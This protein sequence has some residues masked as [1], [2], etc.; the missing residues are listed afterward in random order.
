MAILKS[1]CSIFLPRALVVA[2]AAGLFYTIDVQSEQ[3]IL[4][5][6]D[7]GI[8]EL[9][10]RVVS[11]DFDHVVSDLLF[12]SHQAEYHDVITS[13]EWAHLAIHYRAFAAS[14]N[15]YDQVRFIDV[16]G[17]ERVRVNYNRGNP[18]IVADDKLQNK[19]RR[20][21]FQDT[22]NLSRNEIFIS[23][24][25]L[26][27]EHGEVEQPLKP[28]IRF[29]TPVFDHEGNRHGVILLNYLGKPLIDRF[30]R[31]HLLNP[32]RSHLL[33][34]DGYWLHGTSSN[35]EWGFMFSDRKNRTFAHKFPQEWKQ[36]IA[37]ES[38]QFQTEKGLYTFATV[39][40][41][42]EG[43]KS[44]SGAVEAFK[45]SSGYLEASAY[46]W[47]IVSYIPQVE[48]LAETRRGAGN[49]IQLSALLIVLLAIGSWQ[50]A[51]A[52]VQHR[53]DEVAVR[54]SE[55]SLN[56]AQKISSGGSWELDLVTENLW[57]SD[58][59]YRVFEI[60]K[61]EFGASYEAFLAAIHPDD[62]ER[63]NKAYTDSLESK[64]Q[65]SIEHRLLMKDGRVKWV[66]EHCRT[67]YNDEG[68]PTRSI[69]AVQ[70]ITESVQAKN[71][72]LEMNERLK[73]LAS[74]DPLTKVFNRR[75]F[76]QHASR[77][78]ARFKRYGGKIAILFIDADNFKA[79]NDSY[80]H[81]GGDKALIS[82]VETLKAELRNVDVIGRTG[83]DEFA[84]LL[85]ET[86][87]RHAM[88]VAAR[89]C[90]RASS[91]LAFTVSIGV[92]TPSNE[93]DSI[94]ILINN[95]DK[96]MYTAKERGRNQVVN[97]GDS[98]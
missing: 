24:F 55:I 68:V 49:I 86:G 63:V 61:K 40:P 74:T 37:A 25:D 80:G 92:S 76:M 16:T 81:A 9:Q 13:R 50:L 66:K 18:S 43:W 51:K 95:A 64:E 11:A 36:I 26:N 22:L 87:E 7:V 28:M 35:D 67:F 71:D 88:E 77:E 8:V 46:K 98:S 23:P 79:I 89:I 15:I 65:Y 33:N 12:L 19:A 39:H 31:T 73:E 54:N 84:V 82:F 5:V 4:K 20:Y 2:L 91:S 27:I 42:K 30:V 38:G 17:M 44:S 75:F 78:F 45:P 21:Y 93:I 56:E 57:W 83:G 52:R 96:A 60:D 29:G 90:S 53:L 47:K 3:D 34:A 72:M 41:M 62:S 6:Q 59:I 48:F 58:G 14:K 70:D 1:F 85:P 32:D 97:L 69:G 94:E 10:K